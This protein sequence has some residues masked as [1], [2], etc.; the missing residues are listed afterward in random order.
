MLAATKA[1]A[2]SA[3]ADAGVSRC[4]VVTASSVDAALDLACLRGSAAADG[5]RLTTTLGQQQRRLGAASVKEAIVRAC[6][7]GRVGTHN[8][9]A[10]PLLAKEDGRSSGLRERD[11]KRGGLCTFKGQTV[12]AGGGWR[13]IAQAQEGSAGG[14]L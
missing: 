11:A 2:G 5:R 6:G 12:L 10:F 3:W 1:A 4:T 7:K 14:T 8:R 13:S 9:L